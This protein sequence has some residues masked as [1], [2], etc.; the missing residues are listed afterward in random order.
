MADID[1]IDI[2]NLSDASEPFIDEDW[3][4]EPEDLPNPPRDNIPPSDAKSEARYQAIR[5][6]CECLSNQK[7]DLDVF[8]HGLCYGND[9]AVA[10]TLTKKCRRQLMT[11][12]LLPE[13]LDNLHTPPRYSGTRPKAASATLDC[14]AWKHVIRQARG[15]LQEFAQEAQQNDT[16]TYGDLDLEDLGIDKLTA[17]VKTYTPQL[18]RFLT[19]V[20]ET[21]ARVRSRKDQSDFDDNIEPSFVCKVLLESSHKLNIII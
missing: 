12:A 21:K 4:L 8:L 20:G 3:D 14:W 16:G 19:L 9:K 7:L 18:S 11:S 10:D 5:K 17:K 6:V 1:E 2:E 13:I 15:E